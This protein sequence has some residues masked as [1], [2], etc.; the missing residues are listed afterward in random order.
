MS[1]QE[2][3]IVTLLSGGSDENLNF[4]DLTKLLVSLDFQY[5]VK[6]SHHIFFKQGVEEILNLQAKGKLAKGYQVKQVRDVLVRY[7]LNPG[8]LNQ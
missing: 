7:Q 4:D 3:F 2:K 8:E 1:K 6:G 5:R